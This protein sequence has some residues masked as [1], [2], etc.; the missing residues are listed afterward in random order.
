MTPIEEIR[1]RL[2]TCTIPEGAVADYAGTNHYEIHA[3]LPRDALT[4][5][6]WLDGLSELFAD[7]KGPSSTETGKRLG[8]CLDYA[9]S[10]RQDVTDLLSRIDELELQLAKIREKSAHT[11]G[12]FAGWRRLIN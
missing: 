8:A 3:P 6:W 7:S 4:D 2:A 12:I 11:A 10:Y 1:T 5:Y 9:C